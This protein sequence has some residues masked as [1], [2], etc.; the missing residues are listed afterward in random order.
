MEGHFLTSFGQFASNEEKDALTLEYNLTFLN[1]ILYFQASFWEILISSKHLPGIILISMLQL[2]LVEILCTIH[3]AYATRMKLK[4][5]KRSLGERT[6]WE[7]EKLRVLQIFFGMNKHKKSN[8]TERSLECHSFILK[9][10]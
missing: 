1:K 5:Q 7:K 9:M 10:L 8:P 2:Y 3:L 6:Q 4:L